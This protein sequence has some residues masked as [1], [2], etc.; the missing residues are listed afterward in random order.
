MIF[1]GEN[2]ASAARP[3]VRSNPNIDNDAFS[4]SVLLNSFKDMPWIVVVSKQVVLLPRN[5]QV[6]FDCTLHN[7]RTQGQSCVHLATHSCMQRG[8]HMH[9]PVSAAIQQTD[10]HHTLRCTF[11]FISTRT[12]FH[13]LCGSVAKLFSGPL[14]THRHTQT[15]LKAQPWAR[16]SPS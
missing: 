16:L 4:C 8:E 10:T 11:S 2:I 1:Q 14:C 5:L 9:T 6:L 3:S 7:A 13:L 12:S 15:C